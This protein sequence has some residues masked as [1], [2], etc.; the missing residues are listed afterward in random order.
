M[1]P[2]TNPRTNP[3]NQK[4]IGIYKMA[5]EEKLDMKHALYK[6]Y[7][8]MHNIND[9]VKAPHKSN[10]NKNNNKINHTS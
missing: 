5:S 7:G 10:K 2:Q 1:I 3:L 8:Y 4:Y 6:I 9:R